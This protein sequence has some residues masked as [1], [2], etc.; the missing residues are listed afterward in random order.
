MIKAVGVCASRRE[1]MTTSRLV[2]FEF[3]F[4]YDEVHHENKGEVEIVFTDDELEIKCLVDA[5]FLKDSIGAGQQ[6]HTCSWS[7]LRIISANKEIFGDFTISFKN[8]TVFLGR[9]HHAPTNITFFEERHS[10]ENIQT[11]LKGEPIILK[12]QLQYSNELFLHNIAIFEKLSETIGNF[13]FVVGKEE[14]LV[15]KEILSAQ[16][17][18]LAEIIENSLFKEHILD[19]PKIFKLMLNFLNSKKF[20]TFDPEDVM[21]LMVLANK[22]KVKLLV[23]LCA[24]RLSC[25]LTSDNALEVLICAHVAKSQFLKDCVLEFI[26]KEKEE[27]VKLDNYKKLKNHPDLLFEIAKL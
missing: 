21:K 2:K 20:V 13:T 9:I 27:I 6:Q 25:Y 14:V 1:L 3:S 10:L 8:K 5:L 16:S 23:N 18:V 15:N 24:Y 19:D 17:S 12:L 7:Y 26:K 11:A 22:Y 4:S